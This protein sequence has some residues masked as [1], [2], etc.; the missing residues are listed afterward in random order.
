[1]KNRSAFR[2]LTILVVVTTVGVFLAGT[3]AAAATITLTGVS[4]GQVYT[5]PASIS[6]TASTTGAV[7]S[8]SRIYV[9]DGNTLLFFRPFNV[10]NYSMNFIWVDP[11][12]GS[13]ALR[14]TVKDSSVSNVTSAI[15]VSV[16]GSGLG[17]YGI[18]NF[19]TI[20]A[21][22]NKD[23]P[24]VLGAN[25]IVSNRSS[26][27]SGPLRVRFFT[28]QTYFHDTN[29]PPNPVF[30]ENVQGPVLT[31][32]GIVSNATVTFMLLTSSNVTCPISTGEF[33]QEGLQYHIY[34]VL[35]EQVGIKWAQ[36][37][38]TKMFSSVPVIFF[39]YND[40]VVGI[41]PLPN[42]NTFSY[43][44]NLVIFGPTNIIEGT[45]TNLF[46]I[47]ALSDGATGTVNAAWS[48]TPI[49]IGPTGTM[50]AP[51]VNGDTQTMVTATFQRRTTRT[52]TRTV[53]IRNLVTPPAIT[54]HP[55]NTVV[56]IGSNATFSVTASGDPPLKYQWR[57]NGT[58]VV[59]GTNTTLVITNAQVF[60]NGTFTVVITNSALAVTS[61][62][63]LLTVVARPGL[64]LP[65]VLTNKTFQLRI[66]GTTGSV[67]RVEQSTNLSTWFALSN[68]TMLSNPV[69]FTDPG[70]T[71]L[72]RRFYRAWVGP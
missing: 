38:R 56:A 68:F 26:S 6:M 7:G 18:S 5:N 28:T 55:T 11:P 47:G 41:E 10:T 21:V 37:D 46:A 67:V 25:L 14:A 36:I 58:N 30:N 33:G 51:L 1:M 43:L 49:S 48:A 32:S 22:P 59:N 9:Y 63:A 42:T 62:P 24:T 3:R 31:H 39:P 69:T 16:V 12:I 70:A 23:T 19:V 34:A 29:Q 72:P 52:A 2:W 61:N 20:P 40:G 60:T 15:N 17:F 57:R 64:S 44:T 4:N 66:S 53:T 65:K 35:E 71:N 45:V 50:T 8:D 13:H 54:A 27:A